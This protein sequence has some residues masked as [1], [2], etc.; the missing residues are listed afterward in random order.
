M[1]SFPAPFSES[2][3]SHA[4]HGTATVRHSPRFTCIF[5]LCEIDFFQPRYTRRAS[6]LMALLSFK[7]S[8]RQIHVVLPLRRA[9]GSI[10]GARRSPPAVASSRRTTSGNRTASTSTY[11]ATGRLSAG[12]LHRRQ[13]SAGGGG[14]RH[15]S[16]TPVPSFHGCIGGK[17]CTS[18]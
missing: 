7:M 10:P 16:S 6:I 5:P 3:R 14:A 17:K 8:H 18:G 2:L 9:P 1:S 13:L 12:P 15:E 4:L 11:P